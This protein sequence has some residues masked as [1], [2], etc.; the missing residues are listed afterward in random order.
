MS[1]KYERIIS[2]F[3]ITSVNLDY[4]G[5]SGTPQGLNRVELAGVLAGLEDKRYELG[6]MFITQDYAKFSLVANYVLLEA[7]KII[8]REKWKLPRGKYL[9]KRMCQL[10]VIEVLAPKL[11][12][13]CR[14]HGQYFDLK[15]NLVIDCKKC[16]GTGGGTIFSITRRAKL[17]DV[18]PSNFRKNWQSKYDAIYM[19]AYNWLM[20]V[21]EHINRKG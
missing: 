20:D 19:I 6:F 15:N 9:A 5:P 21:F 3:N 13:N 17:L 4:V 2:R 10:A 12:R 7:S 8:V 14:G 16:H 11:C 18:E 1:N